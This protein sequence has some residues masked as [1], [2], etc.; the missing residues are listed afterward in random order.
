MKK[1]S[2]LI[3]LFIILGF[4]S[5]KYYVSTSLF[6]FKQDSSSVQITMKIFKDD[7]INLIN[8]NYGID[9]ENFQ[10]LNSNEI[11]SLIKK[12]L[13]SNLLINFDD[14]KHEFFYLGSEENNE[15]IIFYLELENILPFKSI[16]LQN[17][18]L[19]DLHDEQQNI[20]HLK[21]GNKKRSFILRKDSPV[22]TFEF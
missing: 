4:S 12:Y 9:L 1:F 11:K 17:T 19:F 3:I 18:I 16:K 15:M 20:I 21:N 13:L 5:H 7:F 10:N 6:V 8:K 22:T 2:F 14:R